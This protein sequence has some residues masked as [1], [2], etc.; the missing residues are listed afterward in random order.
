MHIDGNIQLADKVAVS[1]SEGASSI[2]GDIIDFGGRTVKGK[3]KSYAGYRFQGPL[4]YMNFEIHG[5]AKS[6][7]TASALARGVFR[8][9]TADRATLKGATKKDV[10]LSDVYTASE[11]IEAQYFSVPLPGHIDYGRYLGLLIANVATG[12]GNR[13]LRGFDISIWLS[14]QPITNPYNTYVESDT[15]A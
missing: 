9:H 8:I 15:S 14:P 3:F 13:S 4:I 6:D 11:V 5:D 12:T 7:T 1:I 2:V 10:W